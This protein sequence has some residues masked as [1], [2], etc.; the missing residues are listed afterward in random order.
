MLLSNEK[1]TFFKGEIRLGTHKG[2]NIIFD[3]GHETRSEKK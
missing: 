3:H 1:L 2:G